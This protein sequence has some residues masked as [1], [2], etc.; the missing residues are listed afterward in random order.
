MRNRIACRGHSTARKHTCCKYSSINTSTHSAQPSQSIHRRYTALHPPT[1]EA[2]TLPPVLLT[3]EVSFNK[4]YNSIT[5]DNSA[6]SFEF[7]KISLITHSLSSVTRWKA[8]FIFSSLQPSYSPL[9]H[10]PSL[11]TKLLSFAFFF[12]FHRAHPSF[13]SISTET[14]VFVTFL[15]WAL[16]HSNECLCCFSP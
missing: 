11:A 8:I 16:W 14:G 6:E 12:F 7:F 10:S 15:V 4:M 5:A 9:N 2:Y 3:L 1:L 13:V